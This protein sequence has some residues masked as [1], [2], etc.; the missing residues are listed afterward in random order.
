[1]VLLLLCWL[2]APAV[3]LITAGVLLI[4]MCRLLRVPPVQAAEALALVLSALHPTAIGPSPE[5]KISSMARAVVSP[6]NED[7]QDAA[8]L[9]ADPLAVE[10]RA[11]DAAGSFLSSRGY[12]ADAAVHCRSPACG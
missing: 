6:A 4:G 12:P 7:A 5:R 8:G 10:R 1:M 9:G 11:D 3:V 2:L